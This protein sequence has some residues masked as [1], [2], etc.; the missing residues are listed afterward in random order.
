[1]YAITIRIKVGAYAVVAAT[2]PCGQDDT[3]NFGASSGGVIVTL[4]DAT[5]GKDES[6]GGV[7]F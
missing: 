7:E 2:A 4:C 1:M 3:D 6:V 5:S